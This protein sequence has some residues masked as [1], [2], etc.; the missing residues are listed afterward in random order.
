M[1]DRQINSFKVEVDE[2]DLPD[3][4]ADAK[5][6]ALANEEASRHQRA[7]DAKKA[8]LQYEPSKGAEIRI[9]GA[10]TAGCE[11][12]L[13]KGIVINVPFMVRSDFTTYTQDQEDELNQF[14]ARASRLSVTHILLVYDLGCYRL[15]PKKYW[16]EHTP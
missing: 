7:I 8:L 6:A 12:Q 4:D 11:Y 15:I 10:D 2:S 3:E 16:K 1:S 13:M 5:R 14:L 9:V